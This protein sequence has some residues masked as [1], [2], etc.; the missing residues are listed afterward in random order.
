MTPRDFV[1]QR[2]IWRDFPNANSCLFH[3]RSID[4]PS[5]PLIPK[6]IRGETIISGFYIQDDLT[7]PGHSILGIISHTDIKGNIPTWLVN[8]VTPKASINWI[9]NLSKGCKMV[10]SMK[11]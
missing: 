7:R 5:C 9:E 6:L 10:L 4:Y 8:T 1:Q 11:I 2:K 3:F